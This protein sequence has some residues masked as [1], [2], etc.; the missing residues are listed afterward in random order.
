M[1]GYI[2]EHQNTKSF[3]MMAWISFAVS[4]VG[5]IVGLYYL[6]ADPAITGFLV[7]AYL[8]SLTSCLTL[9]KVVRDKHEADKFL[10]KLENAKTEKF[11]AENQ[12]VDK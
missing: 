1:N 11:F 12:L 9:A 7:M 3:D 4:F 6:K 5:M 8:F 2:Y 10:N